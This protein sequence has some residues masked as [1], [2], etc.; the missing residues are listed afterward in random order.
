MGVLIGIAAGTALT[1]LAAN[2]YSIFQPGGDLQGTWNS[3]TLTAGAVNLAGSEVTGTLPVTLGGSGLAS[4]AQG[5]TLYG[6]AS[7]TVSALAKNTTATRYLANTGTSNNPAWAQVNL[8]NGIT[9][10]LLATSVSAV[11]NWTSNPQATNYQVVLLDA[12]KQVLHANADSTARTYTIPQNSTVAFVIGTVIMIA[13]DSAAAGPDTIAQGTGATL[14]L[15]GTATTGSRTLAV[16]GVAF[17]VKTA[18]NRWIVW[19]VGVT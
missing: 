1:A 3:Q 15:G 9:G 16:G 11:P 6:S 19:G 18:T 8:S 14:V 5:D 13:N 7:N 10:T 17:C 2:V 4:L 12:G